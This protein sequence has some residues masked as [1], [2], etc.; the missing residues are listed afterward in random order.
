[1]LSA[2]RT[3]RSGFY[4]FNDLAPGAHIVGEAMQEGWRAISPQSATVEIAASQ[5]CVG[6]DFWNEPGPPATPIR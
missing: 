1:M 4:R 3:N 5:T 6:V 2:A